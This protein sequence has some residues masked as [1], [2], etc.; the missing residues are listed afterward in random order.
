LVQVSAASLSWP[1]QLDPSSSAHTDLHLGITGLVLAQ[2]LKK[3][4]A[5]P[6]SL[7]LPSSALFGPSALA[8]PDID[9]KDEKYRSTRLLAW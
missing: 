3:V 8:E 5:Q 9:T 1:K 6:C 2:A 4:C 7:N